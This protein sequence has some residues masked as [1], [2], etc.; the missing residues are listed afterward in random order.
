MVLR[1]LYP[2][3]GISHG[4]ETESTAGGGSMAALSAQAEDVGSR[5]GTWRRSVAVKLHLARDNE[6]GPAWLSPS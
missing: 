3:G 1:P 6:L 2:F 5:S 4:L